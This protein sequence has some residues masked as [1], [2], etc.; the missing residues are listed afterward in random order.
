MIETFFDRVQKLLSTEQ[1][2]MSFSDFLRNYQILFFVLI[3]QVKY[4]A[5]K[6]V[7]QHIKYEHHHWVICVDSKMLN[8]LLGQQSGYTK[9]PCFLCYWDSS[10]KANHWK[11][12]N[13]SVREQLKVGDKNVIRDQ[14]VARE[15]NHISS[16]TH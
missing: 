4:D 12:K 3:F 14:F 9:F 15:K 13:W 7:L 10:D 5:I 16:F 1:E 11:T 8:L 6:T 2:M